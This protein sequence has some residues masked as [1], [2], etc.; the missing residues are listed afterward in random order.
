ME[1]HSQ[2]HHFPV[3]LHLRLDWSE[4]DTFGHINNVQFFKYIQASRV[5]YWEHIGL[6]NRYFVEKIGPILVSTGC[7]FKQPLFYPDNITVEVQVEFIKTTSIGLH[8]RIMNGKNE[9]CAEAHDVIV[10]FN[11]E[12]NEKVPIPAEL[13]TAMEKAEEK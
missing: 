1:K 8:H 2:A 13:R 11:F 10:L 7:Q 9:L 3:K 6:M 5:N 12:K 4:M